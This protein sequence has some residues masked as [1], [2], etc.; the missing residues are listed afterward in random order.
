MN[1]VILDSWKS[2]GFKKSQTKTF[3]NGRKTV[4]RLLR[5]DFSNFS[6]TTSPSNLYTEEIVTANT[7]KEIQQPQDADIAT[8]KLVEIDVKHPKR[9]AK[10]SPPQ[11][12]QLSEGYQRTQSHPSMK[13]I[14]RCK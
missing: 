9:G 11:G 13:Q 7:L 5:V 1:T 4:A 12:E 6:T 2:D 3:A 14:P 8:T 10:S